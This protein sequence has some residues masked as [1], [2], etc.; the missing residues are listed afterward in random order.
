MT[1]NE[2]NMISINIIKL[3]MTINDYYN[4]V[5][6]D[7]MT[8]VPIKVEKMI[9]CP[10]SRL[11]IKLINELKDYVT[12]EKQALQSAR[13]SRSEVDKLRGYGEMI[14]DVN[15]IDHPFH[16]GKQFKNATKRLHLNYNNMV[17]QLRKICNHPYLMLEDIKPID[18]DLF[19]RDLIS[20]SGKFCMLER[21]LHIPQA[22]QIRLLCDKKSIYCG[23]TCRLQKDW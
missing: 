9:F 20:S 19:F 21:L 1:Y 2:Y 11:Q 8:E 7:V 23:K 10:I 17:M 22:M 6:S 18:D 16:K 5:K 4:R 12:S 14:Y 3:Q 15:N 13:G